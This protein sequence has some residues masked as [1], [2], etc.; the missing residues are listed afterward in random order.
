M[1]DLSEI[2]TLVET[3]GDAFESFR[4]RVESQISNEKKEREELEAR[5]NRRGVNGADVEV[6]FDPNENKALARFVR[7]GEDHELKSMSVGSDPDGG[8]FVL[9]AQSQTMTTRLYEMSPMRRLA[10]LETITAGDKFE[11]IDDRGEAT[12]TWVGETASRASGATPNLGKIV[13]PVHEIYA[14]QPVTQKLLDDTDRDLGAWISDKITDKFGHSEGTAFITGDGILKPQGLLTYETNTDADETR[15]AGKIQHVVSGN[16]SGFPAS[17]AADVLKTLLWKLRAPYRSGASWV[18]NSN[19]AAT[20]D[21]FKNGQGDYIW[22][23]GMTAGSP[24]SLLGYPVELDEN[25]PDI[26]G[27]NYP[28]AFGN[29]ELAYIIV[30]KAGVKM[31]RDPFTDK[32]N[33]LF[34]AYRRVG[35]GLANDDAVK[36]LK[37]S[38]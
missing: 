12:A 24:P 27:G 5:L 1:T 2:K 34:Y 13:I 26:G 15:T 31:L 33:V 28:I 23:D 20:V 16:A 30:E 29:M 19:T 38:T 7:S 18:M 10:R 6:S 3:Q 36:L 4:N 22:R 14:L 25:M 35:G 9:P 8:Y 17:N 21:K 32:P 37:I 11:E